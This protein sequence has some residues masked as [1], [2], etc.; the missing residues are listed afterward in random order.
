MI[1]F[2]I[3]FNMDVFIK[4]VYA[5]TR[6]HAKLASGGQRTT[7]RNWFSSTIWVLGSNQSQESILIMTFFFQESFLSSKL[8]LLFIKSGVFFLKYFLRHR[9][10]QEERKP[11]V[12]RPTTA[13]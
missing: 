5:H 9:L 12:V 7:C 1:H 4:C 10:K 8:L 2:K 3:P 11:K 13:D 6:T